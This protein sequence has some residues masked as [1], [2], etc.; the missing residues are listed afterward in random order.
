MS[1]TV[2]SVLQAIKYIEDNLQNELSVLNV[3]NFACYSL[4]HFIR[5]FEGI[6][7]H[8]PKDYILRRRV[9][10]AV[11]KLSESK[12]KIIDVCFDYQF[13]SP[14]VFTRA[15]KRILGINP[16]KLQ[17]QDHYPDLTLLSPID[18]DSILHG[19]KLRETEVKLIELDS[20][21]IAGLV[22]LIR[23]DKSII[24]ELWNFLGQELINR[25]INLKKTTFY[26]H[27]FWSNEYDIN[28]FFLMCGFYSPDFKEVPPPLCTR[29][30]PNNR[31]LKFIHKGPVDTIRF[32]YK[33]IF[34]TYL[35]KTDY[36]LISPYDFEVFR[37]TTKDP[38]QPDST[39]EI[40]IPI[41]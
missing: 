4:Y 13:G 17:K 41:N 19:E 20:F 39:T 10:E 29:I 23:N 7:G 11:K 22:T 9:S 32:T 24:S 25:N 6:T 12:K 30:I 38:N 40:L 26:N 15:C 2:D 35:P 1:K 37:D 5:L 3:S 33:Y 21:A 34:Q 27:S 18:K 36:K 14:E 28:G 8:S 31:Y 16:G